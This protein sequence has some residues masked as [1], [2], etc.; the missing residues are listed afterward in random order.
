MLSQKP[1]STAV[2]SGTRT[3]HCIKEEQSWEQKLE[4]LPNK[5]S[6]PWN[7]GTLSQDGLSGSMVSTKPGQVQESEETIVMRVVLELA[8]A[9]RWSP[10]HFRQCFTKIQTAAAG[11]WRAAAMS[12][13][14]SGSVCGPR[15]ARIE[16][17]ME[18][19]EEEGR[20]KQQGPGGLDPWKSTSLSQRNSGSALM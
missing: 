10:A 13:R 11:T 17:A 15:H 9:C 6:M 20:K 1:S 19:Y 14:P 18:G 2:H 12:W 8:K 7:V 5:K 4:E 3:Q 16:K